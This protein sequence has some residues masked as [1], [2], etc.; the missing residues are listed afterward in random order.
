M[1]TP[2]T[3][4]NLAIHDLGHV[5]DYLSKEGHWVLVRQEDLDAH[6]D[7]WE[8]SERVLANTAHELGVYRKRIIRLKARIEELELLVSVA[9]QYVP[10]PQ[11]H[12]RGAVEDELRDW[13]ARAEEVKE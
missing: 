13:H 12:M 8:K 4:K 11:D 10:V 6:A 2:E 7:V 9:R 5:L 1:N 3:L